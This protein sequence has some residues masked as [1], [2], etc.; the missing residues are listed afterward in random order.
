MGVAEDCCSSFSEDICLFSDHRVFLALKNQAEVSPASQRN[1]GTALRYSD[2]TNAS[3]KFP[4]HYRFP[5]KLFSHQSSRRT[6]DDLSY[7]TVNRIFSEQRRWVFHLENIKANVL[8]NGLVRNICV[9]LP[10]SSHKIQN[11]TVYYE[12]KIDL[13]ICCR[14][15]SRT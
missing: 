2:E 12:M 15:S 14:I 13:E 4:F 1:H 6:S 7:R 3:A 5:N 11:L 10:C 9:P 8:K